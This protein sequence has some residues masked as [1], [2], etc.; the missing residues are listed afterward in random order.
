MIVCRRIHVA[1]RHEDDSSSDCDDD[2][3]DHDHGQKVQIVFSVLVLQY[4]Y[5]REDLYF[6]THS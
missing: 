5:C 2:S 4:R 1:M 6:L 3:N